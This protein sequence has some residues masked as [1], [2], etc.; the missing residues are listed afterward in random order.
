MRGLT[1][2]FLLVLRSFNEDE[3]VSVIKRLQASRD[4][5]L[6]ELAA[7]L[8]QDVNEGHFRNSGRARPEDKKKGG[9]GVK[10]RDDK[11]ANSKHKP[12]GGA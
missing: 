5:T 6:K 8:E 11:T 4:K 9:R 7:K 3:I 2:E 12:H 10:H 1:G